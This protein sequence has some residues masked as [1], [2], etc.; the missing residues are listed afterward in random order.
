M[1]GAD[2]AHAGGLRRRAA[3]RGRKALRWIG[4]KSIGVHKS[5]WEW[6]YLR[7]FTTLGITLAVVVATRPQVHHIVAD[8]PWPSWVAGNA[9]Q[10]IWTGV[11][12]LAFV[13]AVA[14]LIFA[15][16]AGAILV[17]PI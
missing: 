4:A 6:M 2:E 15:A 3:T 5:S 9:A 17:I 16:L 7:P 10:T 13:L 8:L 12:T 14:L 11:V 1:T